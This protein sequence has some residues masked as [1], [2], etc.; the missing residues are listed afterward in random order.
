MIINKYELVIY[1]LNNE[2]KENKIASLTFEFDNFVE[3]IDKIIELRKMI[4]N[5]EI[6]I[7]IN[8]NERFACADAF[9]VSQPIGSIL[10]KT[11]LF[12]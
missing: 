7:V 5:K 1:P 9:S 8:N 3:M 10:D 2:D 12:S 6:M 11:Q 4:D